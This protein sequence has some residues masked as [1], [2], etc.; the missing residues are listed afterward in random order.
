[1][2]QQAKGSASLVLAEPLEVGR[3]HFLQ[4]I[5]FLTAAVALAGSCKS[6]SREKVL[7][8][9]VQNVVVPDAAAVGEASRRLRGAI[10]AF[11]SVPST[12]TLALVRSEWKGAIV[13]WKR[14]GCFRGGPAV[15]AGA[16]GRVLSWP[17]RVSVID[18]FIASDKPTTAGFLDERG[19]GANG[20]F[21]LEY[22]VHPSKAPDDEI[23]AGFVGAERARRR[24]YI[25][26]LARDVLM[27]A[28]GFVTDLADGRAFAEAFARDGDA[29]LSGLVSGMGA[30]IQRVSANSMDRAL[31][32]GGANGLALDEVE[33]GPSGSSREIVLAEIEGTQRLYGEKDAGLG[34]LVRAASAQTDERI[35]EAFTRAVASLTQMKA[36]LEQ[37]AMT[38]RPLLETANAAIKALEK[39]LRVDVARALDVKIG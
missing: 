16:C 32:T 20:L 19:D 28:Q 6:Q 25:A 39:A 35:R 13:A 38:E 17:A 37:V 4:Q 36:P 30:T 27:R 9:L 2:S 23:V 29:S 18:E 14:L 34:H 12:S 22:L 24:R 33:G 10:T 3:R 26:E 31:A 21:A 1:M 7:A 15:A 11:V 8:A 5:G